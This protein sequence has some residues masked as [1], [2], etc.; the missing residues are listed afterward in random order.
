MATR[1]VKRTW[2]TKHYQYYTTTEGV[3]A[4]KLVLRVAAFTTDGWLVHP[5]QFTEWPKAKTFRKKIDAKA[6]LDTKL[7]EKLD[8]VTVKPGELCN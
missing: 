7:W 1:I 2:I 4:F 8:V 5:E 3:I 6:R